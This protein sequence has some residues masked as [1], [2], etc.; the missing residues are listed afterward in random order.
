[1]GLK[2]EFESKRCF[3]GCQGELASGVDLSAK[4][5]RNRA[6]HSRHVRFVNAV[7]QAVLIQLPVLLDGEGQTQLLG[8]C[9]GHF[10]YVWISEV[11]S[12]Q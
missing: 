10:G 3:Y 7:R 12:W 11:F 2:A 9:L 8:G 4:G 1:M 6:R 5:A